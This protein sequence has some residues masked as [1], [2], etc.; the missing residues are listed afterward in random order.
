MGS[1]RQESGWP[2]DHV[3]PGLVSVADTSQTWMQL[4]VPGA[5]G[6]NIFT[7]KG[8]WELGVLATQA[9][10]LLGDFFQ[11]MES[12][13][14]KESEKLSSLTSTCP[15]EG[16]QDNE[17]FGLT[18]GHT[19]MVSSCCVRPLLIL[20]L[21]L[22]LCPLGRPFS[23]NACDSQPRPSPARAPSPEKCKTRH[24]NALDTK[25]R[26]LRQYIG[27][28]LWLWFSPLS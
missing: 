26:F 28:K 10:Q 5:G 11:V 17:G 15:G 20:L 14:W 6:D 12:E 27:M 4:V 18:R 2:I 19:A 13:I 23:H 8:C 9:L 1:I 3:R 21:C 24:S 16:H 22:G 7:D 25:S